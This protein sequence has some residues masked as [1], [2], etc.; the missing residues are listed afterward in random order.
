MF[1]CFLWEIEEV[2][3]SADGSKKRQQKELVHKR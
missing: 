2:Q 3:G 1:D